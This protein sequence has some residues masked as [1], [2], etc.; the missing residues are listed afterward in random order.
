MVRMP[1]GLSLLSALALSCAAAGLVVPA[2]SAQT[3]QTLS[4]GQGVTLTSPPG[5]TLTAPT[6]GRLNSYG[7]SVH[8]EGV[9]F[10]SN[11]PGLSAAPGAQ[12]VILH[13]TTSW[14]ED[15]I[16]G[17][18]SVASQTSL[19]VTSGSQSAPLTVQETYPS[20]DDEYYAAAVAI[21]APADLTLTAGGILPQTFDLR[22]GHRVGTS[23]TALYRDGTQP[24]VAVQPGAVTSFAASSSAGTATGKFG[25][26]Y[27]YLQYWQPYSTTLAPSAD[28][29]YL[30]VEFVHTQFSVPGYPGDAIGAV[31]PLAAS[32]VKFVLSGGQTIPATVVPE[33]NR[34]LDVFY[35]NFYAL[36]P[37]GITSFEVVV[38]P[39]S[40]PVEI[41]NTGVYQN[42]QITLTVASP[43]QQSVTLPPSWTP[44]APPAAAPGTSSPSLAPSHRSSNSSGGFPW[45]VVGLVLV[46]AA[47]AV[48][49]V[50]RRR[51]APALHPTPVHW[52]PA[53]LSAAA[54]RLLSGSSQ[55]ARPLL[56]LPPGHIDGTVHP[57][58][59]AVPAAGPT[60]AIRLLGPLEVEGLVKPIRKRPVQR[61]LVVLA[62]T[63]NRPMGGDELAMAVSS[64]SNRDP[65]VESLQSYAS[66]L[67]SALPPGML[68]EADGDGYRLDHSRM[69]VDWLAV[70]AV[71]REDPE[72]PGWAERA[73][74]ALEL[75]RG[76]PLEGSTW[77]GI[78]PVVRS[79]QATI[80]ELARRLAAQLVTAGDPAGAER[81]IARGL[82]AVPGA[83]GL[84]ERRLEAAAAGSGY[85]LERAWTD[86]K[87]DLR[88]DAGLIY[89]VYQRLRQEVA[90]RPPANA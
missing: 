28:Q 4:P 25:V 56:E 69:T 44:P 5:V 19:A 67:R 80:E 75:I 83:V 11:I 42:K 50:M 38:T 20:P 85:G 72:S 32:S 87:E 63:P 6:D 79:I 39:G 24:M 51:Q 41:D 49:G 36:V 82:V 61:L 15:T 8:I 46:I 70:E 7:T 53:R 74:A 76:K 60:L 66:N 86:A 29:A 47:V 77:E 40:F 55:P 26:D 23:P 48:V 89:N 18:A 37:A 71:S 62:V 21:S 30:D 68:P 64:R 27:A 1:R 12:L 65:K 3:V 17:A 81:A 33:Y 58:E 13:V 31:Q 9:A 73:V 16:E 14:D 84:W 54:T 52:P 35:G 90:A 2:A 45:L 43:L 34:L 59:P 88:S 22:A 78:G 10:A 57:L